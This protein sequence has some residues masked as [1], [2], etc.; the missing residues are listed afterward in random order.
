[1]LMSTPIKF[2]CEFAD[3]S[4]ERERARSEQQSGERRET[5]NTLARRALTLS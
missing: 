3:A 1:M 4:V 5:C 2:F